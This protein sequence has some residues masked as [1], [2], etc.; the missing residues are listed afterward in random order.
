[1]R[2]FFEWSKIVVRG[3]EKGTKKT[4][5]PNCSHERK[6]KKDPCLYVNFESGVAKCFNCDALSFRDD[7]TS[8]IEQTYTQ[9]PQE[10]QNYTNLS[11]GMVKFCSDRGIRQETLIHFGVTEETQYQPAKQKELNNIVFNYFEGDKVVNKKYRSA[12]KDFTQTK[13]GKPLFYNVNSII[14]ETECFIVEGEFDVLAMYEAG[15]TNVISLPNGANDRDD[16]WINSEKYIKDI[17][18]FIIATDTDE[19]GIIVRDKIAQRLGRYR[20]V[21]LEFEHK[22]ANGELINGNLKKSVQNIQRFPCSGTFTVEDLYPD[23]L[24]LYDEGLPKTIKINDPNWNRFNDTFSLLRGQLVVGTGIPSHGKSSF[25]EFHVLRLIY[26][27]NFKASFFSPEHSPMEMFQSRLI[28]KS[29]GKPFFNSKD[30]VER[31]TKS[32]IERYKT[33]ANEKIYITNPDNGDFATWNW[34]FEK[35][36]EQ[37]YT[38]GIDIFVIDAFNKVLMDKGK[39]GK[40]GIDEVLTKL[41][42]FA[43][44]NNVLIFL[45]AHPTKMKKKDDGTYEM[46]TLYD[47]SGTSDF[48]NQAHAGFAVHRHFG[49]EIEDGYTRFVNLKTKWSFQG[50]IGDHVDLTYHPPTE[51]YYPVGSRPDLTDFTQS[52]Q[53]KQSEI[54]EQPTALTANLNFDGEPLDEAPF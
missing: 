18:R 51:R 23:I 19:K 6:K 25:S 1:M 48:R 15:I 12:R 3:S 38:F 24:R 9:P 52:A 20:C 11:N 14:G 43:Q 53:I 22:D 2:T 29:V 27:H 5:C 39:G 13:N 37:M 44:M 49:N 7:K 33:W 4:T 54:F 34:L 16:V 35:F 50:N 17:E 46:P 47:V 10:W 26:D 42:A 21:F 41:T 31:I 32:D 30:G 36:K 28:Q 40:E 45:I 8:H